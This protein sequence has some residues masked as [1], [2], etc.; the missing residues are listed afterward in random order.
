MD[1]EDIL[2]QVY[3][4][5]KGKSFVEKK[6]FCNKCLDKGIKLSNFLRGNLSRIFILIV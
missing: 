6:T 1:K 4:V 3:I 5:K 2:Q